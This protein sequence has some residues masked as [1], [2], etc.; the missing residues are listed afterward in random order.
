MA[1]YVTKS[2][3]V[4]LMDGTKKK[5][6]I[7]GKDKAEAQQKYD[8]MKL[9]YDM[10]LL[11]INGNT[12]FKKWSETWLKTY[13]KPKVTEGTYKDIKCIVNRNFTDYIGALK[14]SEIKAVHLQNCLNRMEGKSNSHIKKA[15]MY[16]KNIMQKAIINEIINKDPSLCIESPKG[17]EGH[18]RA[19]TDKEIEIFKKVIP[20]HHRGAFFG[21]MLACGLRPQEVR[22]LTW[23]DLDLTEGKE[24]VKVKQAVESRSKNIKDPK[25]ES[26]FR[27]IPIA[28]WY[29][30]IIKEVSKTNSVL[31]FP[32]EL[33]KPLDEQRYLKGWS[34][35][36]RMM[37]IEA[38]AKLERNKIIIHAIAQDLIP[39]CLRHT[40]ATDLAEKGVDM[41]T[42]QYLLGHAD[43][44]VTANIYTHVTNNM[45]DNA[46]DKINGKKTDGDTG[47]TQ[48]EE[49]QA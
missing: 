21:I 49:R 37:D 40:Y 8:E 23:G 24:T 34:S 25:T 15:R 22:A 38:G 1:K 4:K 44:R 14:M 19:L 7:R 28:D 27:E 31:V 6:K 20:L 2:L 43:I 18:R 26:G 30:P 45:L 5:L 11:T 16:I 42:A 48:E 13:K 41:K 36:V 32:N 9:K 10:G 29:I 33:G 3:T 39:Y 47:G 17:T 12:I 35:F 46:R